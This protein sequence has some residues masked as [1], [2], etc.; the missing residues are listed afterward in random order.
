M[1][2]QVILKSVYGRTTV[3]PA[4]PVS[5]GFAELAGMLTL[6]ERSIR[7]IKTMGYTVEVIQEVKSL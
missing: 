7:I 1:K 2:I 5:R 3:Y 4:C 6:T